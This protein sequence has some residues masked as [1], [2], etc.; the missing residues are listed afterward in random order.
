MVST[1]RAY[2]IGFT[3]HREDLSFLFILGYGI[4]WVMGPISEWPSRNGRF[5]TSYRLG[6]GIGL[7]LTISPHSISILDGEMPIKYP[8]EII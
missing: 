1:L 7:I 8:W 3:F 5:L 4:G 6:D 2:G